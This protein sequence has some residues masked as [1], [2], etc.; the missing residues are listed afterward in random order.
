MERL[1]RTCVALLVVSLLLTTYSGLKVNTMARQLEELRNGA[2][3]ASAQQLQNLQSELSSVRRALQELQEAAEWVTP[4]DITI[5]QR[6]GDI[7]PVAMDWQVKELTEG[8]TVTL[9]LKHEDDLDYTTYEASST[10]GGGY[11]VILEYP[12]RIDPELKVGITHTYS[13]PGHKESIQAVPP[14][15]YSEN[16]YDYYI[17]VSAGGQLRTTEVGS[18]D[19]GKVGGLE[20]GPMS[21]EV[22]HEGGDLRVTVSEEPQF[23]RRFRPTKATFQIVSGETKIIVP[24]TMS[25]KPQDDV[26]K[27]DGE[28]K[29]APVSVDHYLLILE[30]SDGTEVRTV[31]KVIDI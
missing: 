2:V 23:V 28:V 6:Q 19:L 3:N 13:K 27:F 7:I 21:M 31:E 11:R 18:I 10:G 26:R 16:R 14:I 1:F 8:S 25:A 5:G 30:Y 29:D 12:Y 24:L 15:G 17:S 4:V 20:A 9:Y 22:H